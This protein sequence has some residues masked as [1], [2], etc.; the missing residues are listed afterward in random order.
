MNTTYTVAL[1]DFVATAIYGIPK[2]KLTNTGRDMRDVMIA[3]LK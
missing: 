2:E 1:I 3:G